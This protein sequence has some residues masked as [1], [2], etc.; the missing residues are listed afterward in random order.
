MVRSLLLVPCLLVC[1]ACATPFPIDSL[2][3]GMATETVRE[4]FGE[5]E[6]IEAEPE[7]V[8]SSW[9][10]LH[11]E[12]EPVPLTA[13]PMSLR[14]AV[15]SVWGVPLS[16]GIA[17]MDLMSDELTGI[18]WNHFYISRA[19]VVLQFEQG[20][21]VRWE[22]FPDIRLSLDTGSGYSEYDW[23]WMNQQQWWVDTAHHNAGHT[24]HHH[25]PGC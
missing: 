16:W 15:A 10:Y 14:V 7:G 17:L 22:V 3:E 18:N 5:P 4:S 2:E 11:E 24:L 23:T 13:G 20:K 1:V 9:T 12:L 6:A 8:D 25:G 21:L 19:P